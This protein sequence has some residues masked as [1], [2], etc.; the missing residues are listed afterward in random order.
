MISKNN[1][2]NDH[3][4]IHNFQNLFCIIHVHLWFTIKNDLKDIFYVSVIYMFENL[5]FLN[6]MN[7]FT[8][9]LHLIMKF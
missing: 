5:F 1:S 9:E 8:F 4:D 3:K 6:V 2:N 7:I